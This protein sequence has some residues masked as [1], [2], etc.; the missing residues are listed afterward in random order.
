MAEREG[1]ILHLYD[2]VPN[3][4]VQSGYVMLNE[5]ANCEDQKRRLTPKVQVI[6]WAGLRYVVTM[7]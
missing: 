1:V 4:I 5:S 6:I 3:E 2:R 7:Y